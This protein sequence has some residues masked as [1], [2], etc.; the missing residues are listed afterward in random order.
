MAYDM[1]EMN[2]D[3]QRAESEKECLSAIDVI[4]NTAPSQYDRDVVRMMSIKMFASV[5]TTYAFEECARLVE[6]FSEVSAQL[7]RKASLEKLNRF[8]P[9]EELKKSY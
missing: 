6:P 8:D 7:I 9:I 2:L 4:D 3:E 1:R 5:L